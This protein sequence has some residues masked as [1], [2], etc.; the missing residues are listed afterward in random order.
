MKGGHSQVPTV[1]VLAA[2]TDW[3][4]QLRESERAG[5]ALPT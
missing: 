5:L 4:A 1:G 2:G 3:R